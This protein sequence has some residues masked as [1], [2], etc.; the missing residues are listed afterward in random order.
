MRAIVIVFTRR[1]AHLLC[2]SS[3]VFCLHFQES[4][5]SEFPD[6]P[7]GRFLAD[8]KEREGTERIKGG[9]WETVGEGKRWEKGKGGRRER[10]GEGKGREK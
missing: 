2:E 5:G 10:E 9:R 1:L 8:L 3:H 4:S 7:H 6:G